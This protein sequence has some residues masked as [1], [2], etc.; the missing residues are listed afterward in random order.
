M[1]QFVKVILGLY[2]F[3]EPQKII[4]EA[5]KTYMISRSDLNANQIRFL[6]TLKNVFLQKKHIEMADLYD[7]PFTNIGKAPIPLFKE[8]ELKELVVMCK[9]V[10]NEAF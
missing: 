6:I 3:P 10:E 9:S 4:G 7:A 1:V 2:S 8:D 5:F